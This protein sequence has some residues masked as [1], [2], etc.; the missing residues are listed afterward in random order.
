MHVENW[1]QN[2]VFVHLPRDLQEHA[3][4][5]AT[6]DTVSRRNDLDV[7][8]DFSEVDIVGS[9]T[10]SRL[11]ELRSVLRQSGHRLILC[12]LAPATRGVY[13][14]AQ[15]DRLFEFAADESAALAALRSGR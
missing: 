2:V 1:P 15:L 6:I 9:L 13:T 12:H 8:V 4:L 14:V 11:L 10:F 7:V 5:Q 3:E